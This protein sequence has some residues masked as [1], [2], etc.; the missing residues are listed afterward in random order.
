MTLE[1]MKI[2]LD[3]AQTDLALKQSAIKMRTEQAR[4]LNRKNYE[5]IAASSSLRTQIAQLAASIV[6]LEKVQPAGA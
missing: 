5:D 3:K 2:E 1:E 4:E 6:E